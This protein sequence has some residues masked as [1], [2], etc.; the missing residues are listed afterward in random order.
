MPEYDGHYIY[1][2]MAAHVYMLENLL[3][4]TIDPLTMHHNK[5]CSPYFG[6]NASDLA[7]A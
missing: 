2:Q 5:H 6:A 7:Y 1:L 4:C 3:T